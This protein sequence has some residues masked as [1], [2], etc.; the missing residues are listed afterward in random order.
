MIRILFVCH[1]N[2]CR[3]PMAEFVLKDMV[4]RAGIAEQFEI[5]SAATSSEELGNPVYP[6]ARKMLAAHGIDCAGKT[7]RRIKAADYE[8]YDLIIGMDSENMYNMRRAFGGDEEGKLRTLL[9][10]AG[11]PEDSVAD[12]W[13][14]RDFEDTWNDVYEGCIGLLNLLCPAVTLDFS[15]CTE[16]WELYAVMRNRMLW[17]DFYGSNLDALSDILTGLPH[18]G[19]LFTVIMPERNSLCHE[20][21]QRVCEIFTECGK[22]III[23]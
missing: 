12:P 11:R 23:K 1:G 5:A 2:I 17:Q 15:D 4:R 3:S 6:P 13:Y 22:Q 9:S 7:A 21:A 18:Y 16:R 14:T 20:Y 8:D 10:F 19:R